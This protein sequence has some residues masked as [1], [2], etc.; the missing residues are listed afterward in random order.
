MVFKSG[1]L[2]R[3]AFLGKSIA[4]CH[5]LTRVSVNDS[6]GVA[7]DSVIDRLVTIKIS[8]NLL[9]GSGYGVG[10]VYC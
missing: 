2:T 5:Q 7:R 10:P 8:S 9:P 6:G 3:M 4:H 1:R